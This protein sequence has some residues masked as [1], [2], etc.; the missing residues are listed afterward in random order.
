MSR[1]KTRRDARE[2][3]ALH[4]SIGTGL[5]E[6]LEEL[7]DETSAGWPPSTPG[8]RRPG[9]CRAPRPPVSRARAASTTS[10]RRPGPKSFYLLDTE[11]PPAEGELA[12][13]RDWGRLVASSVP[14]PGQTANGRHGGR[15]VRPNGAAVADV[16]GA[17]HLSGPVDAARPDL[18]L[19]DHVTAQAPRAEP[20][21]ARPPAPGPAPLMPEPAHP[22]AAPAGDYDPPL[23]QLVDRVRALRSRIGPG[24]PV[25]IGVAGEPG[26]GKSTLTASL[27]AALQADGTTAVLVP[28]DGFHLAN[29]ALAALGR[30]ERKGAIDTFDGAGYTALLT[31]LR[32]AGSDTVWAPTY[33]RSIEESVANAIAVP[34]GTDVVVTEGNYLLVDDGP[35][36]AVRW[37]LDEAWAVEVDP[38]LR[39]ERLVARHV[40][41]GKPPEQ[42]VG[43]GRGGRRAER[44]LRALHLRPRRPG[45]P[46]HLTDRGSRI[47]CGACRRRGSGRSWPAASAPSATT[48][49]TSRAGFWV[50]VVTFEGELTAVRMDDVRREPDAGS[51]AVGGPGRAAVARARPVRGAPAW[52]TTPTSRAS[53]RCAGGSRPAPSTRST[54]AACWST[55]CPTAPGSA[56]LGARLARGQP[57]PVRRDDRPARGRARDRLCL[58]GGLPGAPRSSG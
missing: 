20:G 19:P 32:G 37:L 52:T 33:D 12:R 50:V 40:E 26:S 36:S 8:W 54:S 5:R 42:A 18:V 10:T 17:A 24:R 38:D 16:D 27:V 53:P 25:L 58:T 47:R 57:G 1:Q 28:M 30:A 44:G 3:G 48:P 46:R 55:T 6:W 34:A 15:V 45:R 9:I 51:A 35:W 49:T 23:Y 41:F 21:A 4:G 22:R 43:V 56:D 14:A 39:M 13:A 7:P 11:G 31:R 29:V 2:H